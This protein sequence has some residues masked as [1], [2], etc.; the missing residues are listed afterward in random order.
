MEKPPEAAYIPF[1]KWIVTAALL[2][3]SAPA[4]ADN[5]CPDGTPIVNNYCKDDPVGTKDVPILPPT[6]PDCWYDLTS[7]GLV[8][9]CEEGA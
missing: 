5:L 8:E 4:L 2:L 6:K 9:R 7:K 3:F 1:M